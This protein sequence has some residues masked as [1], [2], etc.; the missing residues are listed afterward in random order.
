MQPV[1][2]TSPKPEEQIA[3]IASLIPQTA[4]RVFVDGHSAV[5]KSRICRPLSESSG[6]IHVQLD[7]LLK[8]DLP[9]SAKY[10][11]RVDW[12]RVEA[13]LE[14]A[15]GFVIVDGLCLRHL[16]RN[17]RA[18]DDF[19]MYV[20]PEGIP[21]SDEADRQRQFGTDLYV[22]RYRPASQADLLLI[23]PYEVQG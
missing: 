23:V 21:P 5:G 3:E 4:K 6:R 1:L 17:R 19:W 10:V 18:A 8:R 7:N 16:F 13:A 12:R 9:R 20:Q 11:Q 15:S 22:R 14:A 2:R